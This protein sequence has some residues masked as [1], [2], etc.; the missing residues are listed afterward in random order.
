[1]SRFHPELR[2]PKTPIAVLLAT[3]ITYFLEQ[4]T[5]PP[6]EFDLSQPGVGFERNF[7]APPADCVRNFPSRIAG[8]PQR[9]AYDHFNP[10][11]RESLPAKAGI[12]APL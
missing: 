4:Q 7:A 3:A 12:L 2:R 10:F 5:F 9:T 6:V 1:M 11:R 8:S